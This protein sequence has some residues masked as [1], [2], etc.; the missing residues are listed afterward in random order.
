VVRLGLD[1][2]TRFS[3]Y[4]VASER[5]GP[6]LVIWLGIRP[7]ALLKASFSVRQYDSA[8]FNT[9]HRLIYSARIGFGFSPGDV[10]LRIW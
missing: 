3:S 10:P 9:F 2:A 4:R 6:L 5:A 8:D 7:V 1:G